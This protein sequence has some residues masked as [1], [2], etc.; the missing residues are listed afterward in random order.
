M[1]HYPRDR[2]HII[3]LDTHWYTKK[4]ACSKIII[5]SQWRKDQPSIL[6]FFDRL[7]AACALSRCVKHQF[8]WVEN[9]PIEILKKIIEKISNV[10]IQNISSEWSGI[11]NKNLKGSV[12]I[13]SFLSHAQYE[14]M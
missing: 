10:I 12:L 5:F 8:I 14:K 4:S 6:L 2:M 1:V 3:V 11:W 7:Y 13:D 9:C